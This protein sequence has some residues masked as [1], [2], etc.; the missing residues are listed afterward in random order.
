MSLFAAATEAQHLGVQGHNVG[1]RRG[2]Y[3]MAEMV[4]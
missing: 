3:S 4:I 1:E 2:S